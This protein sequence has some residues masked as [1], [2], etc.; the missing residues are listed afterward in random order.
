M[1][2]I[3]SNDDASDADDAPQLWGVEDAS[4]VRLCA[5]KE[6][7]PALL[8]PLDELRR[9]GA[10][11]DCVL[12]A[13]GVQLHVHA[14]VVAAASRHLRA[15]LTSSVFSEGAGELDS[16]SGRR[17]FRLELDGGMGVLSAGALRRLVD[18]MY[19]GELAVGGGDVGLEEL[20]GG[21]ELLELPL[22]SGAIEGYLAGRLSAGTWAEA[23]RLGERF[24]IPALSGAATEWAA[25][26]FAAAAACSAVWQAVP[27]AW[28]AELLAREDLA[29]CSSEAELLSAALSWA[30]GAAEEP[31]GRGAAL[32]GLLALVRLPHLS[33]AHV[34]A[35]ATNSMVRASLDCLRTLADLHCPDAELGA[36]GWSARRKCFLGEQG[37]LLV[38]DRRELAVFRYPQRMMSAERSACRFDAATSTWSHQPTALGEIGLRDPAAATLDGRLYFAG[39]QRDEPNTHLATVERYDVE[40]ATARG[41]GAWETVAPMG[42]PRGG[43]AAAGIGGFLYVAGGCDASGGLAI[44]ER[45]SPAANTW[46]ALPSMITARKSFRLVASNGYV[47]AIGGMRTATVG[48]AAEGYPMSFVEKYH[49]ETQKWMQLASMQSPRYGHAA[50][51]VGSLIYVAGGRSFGRSLLRSCE[52]LDTATNQWSEAVHPPEPWHVVALAYMRGSLYAMCGANEARS[53]G[54]SLLFRESQC[55]RLNAAEDGAAAAWEPLPS[56]KESPL[57]SLHL[58][59]AWGC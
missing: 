8:A 30:E 57:A 31:G 38:R 6:Y 21:A 39:G 14:A 9:A 10:L 4:L 27:R 29:G 50:A 52:R 46:E 45:Y 53:V 55:W 54:S 26:H 19:S 56:E 32:A 1:A 3:G 36:A 18:F 40:A 59:A 5:A 2:H 17:V 35:L 16:H 33:R 22:A 24:V 20:L 47:Y 7:A 28:V 41:A 42:K 23:R 37:L 34:A 11:T 58:P 25:A 49:P 51:A 43:A 44:V 48:E 13:G 15:S 12:S